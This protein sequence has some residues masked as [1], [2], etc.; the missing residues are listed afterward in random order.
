[1]YQN[2]PKTSVCTQLLTLDAATQDAAKLLPNTHT[3]N[4]EFCNFQEEQ[5]IIISETVLSLAG[6]GF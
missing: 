1:M 5:S 3:Q 6:Y 4:M 2:V